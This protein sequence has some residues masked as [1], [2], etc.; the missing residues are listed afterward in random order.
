MVRKLESLEGQEQ[1]ICLKTRQD[2]NFGETIRGQEADTSLASPYKRQ[3]LTK[4]SPVG[5]VLPGRLP[6]A[7]RSTLLQS[8]PSRSASKARSRWPP[9]GSAIESR[10]TMPGRLTCGRTETGRTQDTR[11]STALGMGRGSASLMSQNVGT[12]SRWSPRESSKEGTWG[13]TSPALCSGRGS[14]TDT[15]TDTFIH[16]GAMGTLS[17]WSPRYSFSRP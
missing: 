2:Y 12:L 8:S 9:I 7:T 5:M 3:R 13:T 17:R 11:P 15:F 10:L 4:P 14:D 6:R 16:G 1:V